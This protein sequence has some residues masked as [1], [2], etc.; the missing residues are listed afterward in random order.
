VAPTAT[1]STPPVAR[2]ATHTA[3]IAVADGSLSQRRRLV[4][5]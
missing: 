1:L 2:P 5:R 3:A 4:M